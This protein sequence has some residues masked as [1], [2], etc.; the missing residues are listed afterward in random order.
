MNVTV[1]LRFL[2]PPPPPFLPAPPLSSRVVPI[3]SLTFLSLSLPC[4]PDWRSYQSV[5]V[6]EKTFRVITT[7]IVHF[8]SETAPL[9][10]SFLLLVNHF[11][12]LLSSSERVHFCLIQTLIKP[13]FERRKKEGRKE[14]RNGRRGGKWT[15]RRTL[16]ERKREKERE[17]E[18]GC[19]EQ[20]K[21]VFLRDW[22]VRNGEK[23]KHV[24]PVREDGAVSRVLLTNFQGLFTRDVGQPKWN[25]LYSVTK[26]EH[27]VRVCV[28]YAGSWSWKKKYLPSILNKGLKRESWDLFPWRTYNPFSLTPRRISRFN[29]THPLLG[30]GSKPTHSMTAVEGRR[31]RKKILFVRREEEGDERKKV[32]TSD[33]MYV[34]VKSFFSP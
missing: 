26:M 10:F 32:F 11:C 7:V 20:T 13:P 33:T 2:P 28:I 18:G 8:S 1:P 12:L 27:P 6:Q 21:K 3:F 19:D 30:G 17:R 16:W 34:L 24:L 22:E 29:P 14:K 4:H 9:F 15:E 25:T 23:K 31:R 5:S